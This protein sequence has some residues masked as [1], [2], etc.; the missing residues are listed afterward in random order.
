VSVV[1]PTGYASTP[2]CFNTQ[3]VDFDANCS[4]QTVVSNNEINNTIDFGFYKPTTCPGTGTPGYWKNHPEAWPVA[5]ITIGGK[6]Y[7]KA[8][9]ITL[10]GC[11]DSTNKLFTMFRSLVAA[12][13]NALRGCGGPCIDGTIAA[14]DAWMAQYAP[15]PT[16]MPSTC[17]GNPI[18]KASSSAWKVGEPLYLTLDKY[19]NGQLYVDGLL[20]APSRDYVGDPHPTLCPPQV[21]IIKK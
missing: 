17:G 2:V 21:T 20:C 1:T 14:A 4:P 13:L 12:K 9:A 10:M 3:N 6:T 16:G 8:Q 19:N 15:A 5:S 18:I 11:P 7:T